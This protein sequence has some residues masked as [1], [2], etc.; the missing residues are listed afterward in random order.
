MSWA[1]EIFNASMK[2]KKKGGYRLYY[3]LVPAGG[4][5]LLLKVCC[6]WVSLQA[7]WYKSYRIGNSSAN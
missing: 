6:L 2:A 1:H 4:H 5:L 3:W 7:K